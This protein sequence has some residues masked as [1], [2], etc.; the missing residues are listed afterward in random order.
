MQILK[1]LKNIGGV[2]VRTKD[3]DEYLSQQLQ[4]CDY[5]REYLLELIRA[6]DGEEGL[7]LLEALKD[8]IN[9]MGVTEFSKLVGMKRSAIS[10]LLSQ[11]K[12]PKVDTL[13]KLLA[14]FGLRAK[15]NVEEV[16]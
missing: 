9:T 4:D 5:R 7:S 11:E 8:I 3:F 6:V 2:I 10:R 12:L 16:A 14:P 1:K 15:I 13:D